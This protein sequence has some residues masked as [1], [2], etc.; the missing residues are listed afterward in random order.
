MG[1]RGRCES[2][3]IGR[4][5]RDPIDH[6]CVEVDRGPA[7]AVRAYDRTQPGTTNQNDLLTTSSSFVDQ[8]ARTGDPSPG[9]IVALH[10]CDL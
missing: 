7:A 10:Q 5:G 1:G 3:L 4:G 6:L 8:I 2:V 9:H